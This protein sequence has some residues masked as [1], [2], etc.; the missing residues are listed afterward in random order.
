MT[1]NILIAGQ[2][3]ELTRE[4]AKELWEQLDSLL[5]TRQMF[6]S[7]PPVLPPSPIAGGPG[8]MPPFRKPFMREY[9]GDCNCN[10][11][12]CEHSLYE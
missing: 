4:Q 10:H 8:P 12:P 7:N 9:I 1:I 3:M 2:K 5:G 11:A 6:D